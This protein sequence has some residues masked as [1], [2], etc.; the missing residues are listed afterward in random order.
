MGA[1]AR[2]ATRPLQATNTGQSP[3]PVSMRDGL[4]VLISEL[5]ASGVP[6]LTGK[7]SDADPD[8]MAGPRRGTAGR[9]ETSLTRPDPAMTTS[10]TVSAE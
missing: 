4:A 1:E 6:G 7:H 9:H 10:V 2:P 3:A 5:E 8:F